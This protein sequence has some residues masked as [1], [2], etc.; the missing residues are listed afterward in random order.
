M[1]FCIGTLSGGAS[2][3][4]WG[5]MNH[6]HYSTDKLQTADIP[7][8]QPSLCTGAPNGTLCA[9]GNGNDACRGKGACFIQSNVKFRAMC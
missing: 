8:I 5:K 2:I 4:G 3:S 7:I 6:Y 9:G 1:I